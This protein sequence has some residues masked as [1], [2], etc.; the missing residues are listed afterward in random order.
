M[1]KNWKKEIARDVLALGSIPFY[2]IV[3]IRAII[4]KYKPFVY[5]MVIG[6]VVL[7]ILSLLFKK[8]D[9][10]VGRAI[11]IVF[12]SSVFYDA[13]LYTTFACIMLVGLI[14]SS[15]YILKPK[16]RIRMIVKGIVF[17]VLATATGYYLVPLL[18]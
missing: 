17:G 12:F 5:Q 14:I 6:F 7:V 1:K 8:S 9:Q 10:Y 16:I 15:G 18:V 4:G 11:I 13:Q 3:I 2:I